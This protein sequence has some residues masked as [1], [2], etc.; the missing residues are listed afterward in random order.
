MPCI[1]TL[2]A[3]SSKKMYSSPKKIADYLYAINYT[4]Y[5]VDENLQTISEAE[6]FGCSSVRNGNFYGRNFDYIYNDTPEFIVKVSA[7]KT[8]HASI[9]VAT[10]FGL[11][12]DKINTYDKQL[13][14]I[15][16]L[17]LDGINDCGVICSH[18]VVKIENN[19][20][21]TGTNPGA[22]NLHMMFIPRFVLDNASSAQQAVEL[23]KAHNVYGNLNNKE[24]L[25]I[26]IADANET[27]VV[28]FLNNKV[29][30]TKKDVMTNFYLNIA[31]YN[32]SVNSEDRIE[33]YDYL[34]Y[35]NLTINSMGVERYKILKTNYAEGSTLQGMKNLMNRV[36]Y[37]YAYDIEAENPW[38][39]ESIAI[40][41]IASSKNDINL[42]LQSALLASN[43]WKKRALNDRT[44]VADYWQTVHNSTYDIVNKTL[45]VYVQENYENCYTFNL[46]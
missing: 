23:I 41:L 40:N 14:L 46:K 4:D 5:T 1:A 26:M 11:R 29:I 8:R 12:E 34:S 43:Y 19:Y 17:T 37:S 30:V 33:T 35:N 38:Y 45:H 15:P 3:C 2:S 7:T 13:E 6:S 27:Y 16:N 31:E 42:K 25:H 28:E 10:H 32:Q 18:N 44:P 22:P 20:K 36:K 21:V 9:G 39:S 24:Y